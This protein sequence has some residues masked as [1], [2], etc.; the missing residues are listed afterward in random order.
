MLAYS[1]LLGAGLVVSSP[2]WVTRMLMTSRYR[3]GLRER[4]GRV[5]GRLRRVIAGKRVIWLHAVSVGE[6]LAAARLVGE[7][8]EAL[9]QAGGQPWFLVVST[10]TKTGQAMARERFGA[11]RVFWF[12]L[13]FGWAVRAWMRALEP[14]MVVLMESEL[15]P[16][17][18][19]ECSCQGIPVAVVNARMSDRSFQRAMKVRRVWQWVLVKVA[20]F[21]AQSEETAERLRRLGVPAARVRMTGNLKYDLRH[22]DTEAARVLRPLLDRHAVVVA[23]SLL[24][25]E[26]KLLLEQ[27]ALI[28]IQV[29]EA[30][31]LMAP[32]HPE[33]FDSVAKLIGDDF[34]LCRASELLRRHAAGGGGLG[35]VTP[36]TV[37]L[38]DTVGDLASVY[39]LADV[40]FVGG[41]LAGKG[42]HNPLEPASFGVPVVMGDSFENFREMVNE[43]QAEEGIE[44]VRTAEDLRVSLVRLLKHRVEADALGQ[45]GQQVFQRRRGATARTVSHLLDLLAP[46]TENAAPE[47]AR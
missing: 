15:W 46:V 5:P 47:V 35:R 42:G 40:A 39:S 12:P 3:D 17:L 14:R 37:V 45:R 38:L 34:P 19:A 32:R 26:E 28:R 13:D 31:L 27:G 30:V 25:P 23:G 16:R 8:E 4:L 36:G 44:I 10:T 41:S 22:R 18:L 11:D 9:G 43:M 20:V 7:L 29:P 2:W 1:F 33:R 24:P 6:V 21:L